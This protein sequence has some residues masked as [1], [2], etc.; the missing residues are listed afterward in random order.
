MAIIKKFQSFVSERIEES[1]AVAAVTKPKKPL[2]D[3]VLPEDAAQKVIDRF[4][5]IY[6]KSTKEEKEKINSYFEK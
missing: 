3:N 6:R 4:E 2:S 1:S 5:S